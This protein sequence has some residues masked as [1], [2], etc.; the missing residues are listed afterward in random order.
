MQ[1]RNRTPESSAAHLDVPIRGHRRCPILALNFKRRASSCRRNRSMMAATLIGEL[2]FG[3]D[4]RDATRSSCSPSSASTPCSRT[5]ATNRDPGLWLGAWPAFKRSRRRARRSKQ[6]LWNT[7]AWR[8]CSRPAGRLSSGWTRRSLAPQVLLPLGAHD[9]QPTSRD[10]PGAA[11]IAIHRRREPRSTRCTRHPGRGLPRRT[12]SGRRNAFCNRSAAPS[13]IVHSADEPVAVLASELEGLN[14]DASEPARPADLGADMQAPV[15]MPVPQDPERGASRSGSR[16]GSQD[17]PPG[18]EGLAASDRGPG[19][20]TAAPTRN[21][22][23]DILATA[24]PPGWPGTTEPR[25]T[26]R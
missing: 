24:L 6:E 20:V 11:S 2:A 15:L 17:D 25:S 12:S 7:I 13:A 18:K 3:R 5:S 10:H 4:I 21:S 23:E 26:R 9:S 8:A 16:S 22:Y 14:L 1:P 19:L